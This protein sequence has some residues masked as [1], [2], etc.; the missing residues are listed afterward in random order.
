MM[1]DGGMPVP[2]F[3][4]SFSRRRPEV[5]GEPQG[6]TMTGSRVPLNW[7]VPEPASRFRIAS[8]Y[9]ARPGRLSLQLLNG[10]ALTAAASVR[11]PSVCE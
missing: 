4:G 2:L 9:W 8:A 5:A 1:A 11:D 7:I 3:F 10:G 6:A